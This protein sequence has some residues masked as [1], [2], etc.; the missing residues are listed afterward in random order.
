M[1]L[2]SCRKCVFAMKEFQR[3]SDIFLDRP[4]YQEIVIEESIS[5][6]QISF[7]IETFFEF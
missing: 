4:I 5:G 1:I 3:L 2:E 7:S 6:Q